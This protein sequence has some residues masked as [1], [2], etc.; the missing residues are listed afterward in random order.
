MADEQ[1]PKIELPPEMA[2]PLAAM[3]RHSGNQAEIQ[4]SLSSQLLGHLLSTDS[5]GEGF[6]A[7]R[8][9]GLQNEAMYAD[10]AEQAIERLGDDKTAHR[11]VREY[12]ASDEFKQQFVRDILTT[13]VAFHIEFARIKGDPG[14]PLLKLTGLTPFDDLHTDEDRQLAIEIADAGF[15]H[16]L[17]VLKTAYVEHIL[18]EIHRLSDEQHQRPGRKRQGIKLPTRPLVFPNEP[19]PR[20]LM[21][22]VT[23][24]AWE[25][26]EQGYRLKTP[27][28]DPAK[29]PMSITFASGDH[30]GERDVLETVMGMLPNGE[31]GTAI[32]TL[33]ALPA[34]FFDHNPDSKYNAV[35]EVTIPDFMRYMGFKPKNGAFDRDDQERVWRSIVLLSRLWIPGVTAH[36]KKGQVKA[37]TVGQGTWYAPIIVLQGVQQGPYGLSLPQAV[38]YSLGK[39]FHDYYT[40]GA[41][42][43]SRMLSISPRIMEL[44]GRRDLNPLRLAIYYASQFRINQQG[45]RHG[46]Q[47]VPVKYITLLEQSGIPI[48]RKN[49]ARQFG[50]V[51]A[52]HNELVAKGIIGGFNHPSAPAKNSPFTD[53]AKLIFSVQPPTAFLEVT[54]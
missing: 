34:L 8:D 1:L 39:E 42:D 16:E 54:A 45:L 37:T 43:R 21:H 40:G 17:T 10:I 46:R 11:L 27:I 25:A 22:A 2:K 44:H 9:E 38:R 26:S 53:Y 49:P 51:E 24:H 28:L 41:G 52:W 5:S 36:K 20:A 29:L 15:T 32:K 31:D 23:Q 13:M 30:H 3:T 19:G 14:E 35:Y 33:L 48:D 18:T 47:H 50:R 12:I 4:Y 7:I 6:T